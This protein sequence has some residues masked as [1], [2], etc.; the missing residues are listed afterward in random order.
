ME[1]RFDV[2]KIL[3]ELIRLSRSRRH[4][5]TP[6]MISKIYGKEK[7]AE[8]Y[9]YMWSKQEPARPSSPVR[10]RITDDREK[11]FLGEEIVPAN[12]TSMGAA[13]P[14]PVLGDRERIIKNVIS[15]KTL[16][17]PQ[18]QKSSPPNEVWSAL[19]SIDRPV[20]VAPPTAPRA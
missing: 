20:R 1:G 19:N 16:D 5:I 6:Q 12:R 14:T 11:I 4:E 8:G 2:V 10:I 7:A 18:E 17:A 15:G 3:T 9:T 13:K